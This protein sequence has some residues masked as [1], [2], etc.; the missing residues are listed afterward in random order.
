M[1][2]TLFSIFLID[3]ANSYNFLKKDNKKE[4]RKVYVFF[5]MALGESMNF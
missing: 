3:V 2:K 4:A 1:V 5:G